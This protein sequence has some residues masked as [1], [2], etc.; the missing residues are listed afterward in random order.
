MAR[1]SLYDIQEFVDLRDPNIQS[2]TVPD[3]ELQSLCRKTLA[4]R[5]KR[6]EMA[7]VSHTLL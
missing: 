1:D 7:E 4:S 5:G 2:C 3:A 6:I